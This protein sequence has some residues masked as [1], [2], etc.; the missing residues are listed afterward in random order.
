MPRSPREEFPNSGA[1][2]LRCG[3]SAAECGC[4][5]LD[6]QPFFLIPVFPP[7]DHILFILFVHAIKGLVL[8]FKLPS[9]I[10]VWALNLTKH[11]TAHHTQTSDR[12]QMTQKADQT[13][14]AGRPPAAAA[15]CHIN[16]FPNPQHHRTTDGGFRHGEPTFSSHVCFVAMKVLKKEAV[17]PAPQ[18][19]QPALL[20]CYVDDI[21]E[22]NKS[23]QTQEITGHFTT[24]TNH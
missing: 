11:N 19:G 7:L 14:R 1:R 4:E 12:R 16:L 3:V 24:E 18:H 13:L 22:K 5:D 9:S 17:T 20:R 10:C 8:H 23:G 15:C 6:L 2:T 21:P